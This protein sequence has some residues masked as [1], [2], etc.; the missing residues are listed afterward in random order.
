MKYGQARGYERYCIEKYKTSTGVIGEGISPVNRGNKYNS[1]YHGRTDPR[2]VAFKD[3]YG[4][5]KRLGGEC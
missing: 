5:K 3:A 1:F 4:N 2:A